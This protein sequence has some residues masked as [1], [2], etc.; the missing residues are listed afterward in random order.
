MWKTGARGGLWDPEES[1]AR[2]RRA[3]QASNCDDVVVER[4]DRAAGEARLGRD[5]SV[6]QAALRPL[7][8]TGERPSQAA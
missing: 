5:V 6:E 4:D 3:D 1:P 8:A 2:D 7:V